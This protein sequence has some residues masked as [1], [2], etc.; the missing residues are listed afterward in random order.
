MTLDEAWEVLK[1]GVRVEYGGSRNYIVTA[2]VGQA[3]KSEIYYSLDLAELLDKEK[4][5][6]SADRIRCVVRAALDSVHCTETV[7]KDALLRWVKEN[8]ALYPALAN[9]KE[10][11][12]GEKYVFTLTVDY[13]KY[14]GL[15]VAFDKAIAAAL[16]NR[17][18]HLVFFAGS[19]AEAQRYILE[20]AQWAKSNRKF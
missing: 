7:T 3:K 4:Y 20:C 13:G 11:K 9:F 1:S 15:I 18:E 8:A 14:S 12:F 2:V 17:G 19:F 5:N 10:E 16:K 6:L